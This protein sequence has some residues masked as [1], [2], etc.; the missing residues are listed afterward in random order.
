MAAPSNVYL[1]NGVAVPIHQVGVVKDNCYPALKLSEYAGNILSLFYLDGICVVKDQNGNE[2]FLGIIRNIPSSVNYRMHALNRFSRG[3]VTPAS[4]IKHI[5]LNDAGL[6]TMSTATWIRNDKNSADNIQ[7]VIDVKAAYYL[8]TISVSF[9]MTQVNDPMVYDMSDVA[10]ITPQNTT[11]RHTVQIAFGGDF[12]QRQII[13]M[14]MKVRNAEG[15]FQTEPVQFEITSAVNS[16]SFTKD[17]VEYVVYFRKESYDGFNNIPENSATVQPGIA[18]RGYTDDAFTHTLPAGYYTTGNRIYQV[19]AAGIFVSFAN[20]PGVAEPTPEMPQYQIKANLND[21]G[22]NSSVTVTSLYN[23]APYP[24]PLA[25][26]FNGNYGA[27]DGNNNPVGVQ[28]SFS[29]FMPAGQTTVVVNVLPAVDNPN[30]Q[31]YDVTTFN[32]IY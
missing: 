29:G 14:W 16:M 13:N 24:N 10:T 25:F 20:K 31:Y 6:N 15:E 8:P 17:G 28:R 21:N 30:A 7:C 9:F 32:K 12:E 18:V 5:I 22:A 19:D 1:L 23:M 3:R 4:N 11:Q 2:G 27:I 26:N